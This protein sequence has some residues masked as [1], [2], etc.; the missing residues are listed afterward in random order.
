MSYV[1]ELD[2]MR[3]LPGFTQ[4]LAYVEEAGALEVEFFNAKKFG[5][6]FLQQVPEEFAAFLTFMRCFEK[7]SL[8][9]Y[10]EIGSASGGFIR[11]IHERLG[12][13]EAMMIDDG[14]WQPEGQELNIAAFAE[15][16]KRCVP[17]DS[18]GDDA[19]AFTEAFG[20]HGIIDLIFVDGDHSYEGVKQDIA[21]VLPLA[22]SHTLIAF[23]DTHAVGDYKGSAPDVR[24]AF[25]EAVSAGKLEIIADFAAPIARPLGI[26]VCRKGPKA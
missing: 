19:H 9:R 26:T 11:C 15:K 14:G 18:H 25:L 7:G 3:G 16:V 4:E 23:H 13:E 5:G 12:F 8:K 2:D 22:N 17:C 10:L 1:I 24:R 6:Y 20:E 21:L